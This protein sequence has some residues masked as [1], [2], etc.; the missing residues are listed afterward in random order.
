[1][2]VYTQ[3]KINESYCLRAK[4]TALENASKQATYCSSTLI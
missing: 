3:F 4:K 1:M 2:H